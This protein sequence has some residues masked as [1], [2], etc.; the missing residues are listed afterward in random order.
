MVT[1]CS[2]LDSVF[3][4]LAHPTRR[5][6]LE[7][8]SGGETTVG[9]LAEPFP[10]SRPAISKHLRI[11]EAAGLVETSPDGRISRCSLNASPMREA[12]DWIDDYR[13]YWERK[14]DSLARYLESDS[15]EDSEKPEEK[16]TS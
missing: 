2:Q 14:L 11:L 9:S 8:L 5:A 12:A 7:R 16:E 13:I 4:A 10:V 3:R 6:I 15:A 1:N